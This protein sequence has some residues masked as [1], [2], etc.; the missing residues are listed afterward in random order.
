M[1]SMPPSRPASPSRS[2]ERAGW[3]PA[4]DPVAGRRRASGALRPGT[5]TTRG[6]DRAVPRRARPRART[7]HGTARSG[8]TGCI[9]RLARNA[10]RP[11][12]AHAARRAA[13]CHRVCG[14]RLSGRSP[15]CARHPERRVAL[16]RRVDDVGRGVSADPRA[17]DAQLDGRRCG[18]LGPSR[19][20]T[21]LE[22]SHRTI[23]AESATGARRELAW[24]RMRIVRG[25]LAHR[26]CNRPRLGANSADDDVER[27]PGSRRMARTRSCR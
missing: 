19:I 27:A 22:L 23:P 13:L 12:H 16:S 18:R 21:E 24:A 17:G 3:R 15:D 11:R 26:L 25:E 7:R 5:G 2:S 6:D 9:R 1:P 8:R 20:S 4:R 10:A 14:G